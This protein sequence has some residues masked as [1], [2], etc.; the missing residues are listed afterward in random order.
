MKGTDIQT[1]AFIEGFY[2]HM[3][4]RSMIAPVRPDR[5]VPEVAM[6]QTQARVLAASGLISCGDELAINVASLEAVEKKINQ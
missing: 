4:M 1:T 3:A 5:Q 2:A 6:R